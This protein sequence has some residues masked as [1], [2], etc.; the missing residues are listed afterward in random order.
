M[1]DSTDDFF[2]PEIDD[3]KAQSQT[4]DTAPDESTVMVSSYILGGV[5][6]F[7][8]MLLSYGFG[9]IRLTERVD[10]V[11]DKILFISVVTFIS[12]TILFIL[13]H[14]LWF[15]IEDFWANWWVLGFGL[16]SGLAIGG[17]YAACKLLST[18]VI[19]SP[20]TGQNVLLGAL[21]ALIFLAANN[22]L[23]LSLR[24]FAP[25]D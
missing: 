25:R 6:L 15:K 19:L 13:A 23:R 3:L 16:L 7:L 1:K 10:T 12:W 18:Y 14:A 4:T 24:R 11:A 5:F 2:S 9:W 17:I 20:I 8:A 21:A 22:D